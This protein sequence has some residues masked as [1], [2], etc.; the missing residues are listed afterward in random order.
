M[1]VSA[2]LAADPARWYASGSASCAV[3]GRLGF[4]IG[5]AAARNAVGR[6]VEFFPCALVLDDRWLLT[7]LDTDVYGDDLR[8]F[9]SGGARRRAMRLLS[10]YAGR[11]EGLSGC[12]DRNSNGLRAGPDPSCGCLVFVFVIIV[13][14]VVRWSVDEYADGG[15]P[16]DDGGVR[17]RQS[18][19]G[20]GGF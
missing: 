7:L 9:A 11:G 5:G 14:D 6:E 13:D 12:A 10:D 16:G 19:R 3:S 4:E 1:F 18:G 8:V 17:G 2:W 15:L 20:T